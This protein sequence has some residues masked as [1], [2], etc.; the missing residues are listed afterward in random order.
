MLSRCLTRFLTAQLA[1]KRYHQYW[2]KRVE[3][4]GEKAFESLSQ[5]R[6]SDTVALNCGLLQIPGTYDPKGRAILLFDQSKHD[7]EAYDIPSMLR[8]VWYQMHCVLKASESAQ[9][10]GVVILAHP[11][12]AKFV[13]FDRHLDKALMMSIRGAIPVRIA[14]IHVCHPPSFF[15]ILWP[16]AKVFL[17]ERIRKRVRVHSGSE[18]KVLKALQKFG[19]EKEMIPTCLGGSEELDHEAWIRARH[20]AEAC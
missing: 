14:A 9:K 12:H 13:Q 17:G 1:A 19:M 4:F 20:K 5:V 8:V 6:E 11:K 3:I 15:T 10:H 7:K 18:A 2:D 16:V